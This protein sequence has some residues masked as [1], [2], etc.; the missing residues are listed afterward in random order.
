MQIPKMN[1]AAA[2]SLLAQGH[3][4]FVDSRSPG[5]WASAVEQIPGAIRLSVPEARLRFDSVPQAPFV[6]VYCSEDWQAASLRVARALIEAGYEDVYVLDGGFDDW[7]AFGLPTE[8]KGGA[9][10]APTA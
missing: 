8:A 7:I 4:V 10:L 1:M 5:V 3:A 2:S 6:I 9:A